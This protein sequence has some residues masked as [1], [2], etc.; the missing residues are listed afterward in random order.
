MWLRN[1]LDDILSSPAKVAVLRA[2]LQVASPLSGREII[3]RAGVAYGP[4]WK[5]L[6]ALTASGVLAK[7]EHGRVHTYAVRDP[8]L[9]LIARLRDLFADEKGGTRQAVVDLADRIPEALSIVLFGSEARGDAEPGSDTD[10]LVVVTRRGEDLE[11]RVRDACLDLA[12]R[13]GLAL[14]WHVAD[15]DDLREWDEVDHPFWRNVLADGL[16]LRGESLEGL[17]HRWRRGTAST[18]RPAGSG[19]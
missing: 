18:G 10:V 14:A 3:R 19:T 17:R 12:E 1:P 7:Q 2:V 5:A 6:Q 16:N 4:G 13:H 9:P 15:L 8:G 11:A